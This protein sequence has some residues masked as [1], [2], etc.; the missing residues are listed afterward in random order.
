MKMRADLERCAQ[1]SFDCLRCRPRS[2]GFLHFTPKV[3]VDGEAGETEQ[4]KNQIVFP[5]FRRFRP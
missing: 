5:S 2:A 3:W 4:I 1:L